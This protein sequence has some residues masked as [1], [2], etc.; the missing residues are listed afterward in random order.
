MRQVGVLLQSEDVRRQLFQGIGRLIREDL[1]MDLATPEGIRQAGDYVSG[2]LVSFGVDVEDYMVSFGEQL[3]SRIPRE[4]RMALV[5]RMLPGVARDLAGE[6]VER[7]RDVAARA[8]SR[9]Q[10]SGSS[11]GQVARAAFSRV[12]DFDFTRVLGSATGWL[13]GLVGRDDRER[14]PVVDGVPPVPVALVMEEDDE[15]LSGSV[16]V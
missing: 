8:V 7:G 3:F 1:G 10:E 13:R 4:R 11:I 2:L 12:R 16:A 14:P 5:R 15:D 6:V 9:V